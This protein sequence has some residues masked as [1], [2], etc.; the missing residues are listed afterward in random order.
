MLIDF[1]IKRKL[2]FHKSIK[3]ESTINSDLICWTLFAN[4]LSLLPANVNI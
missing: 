2:R 1:L 3:Y 4:M